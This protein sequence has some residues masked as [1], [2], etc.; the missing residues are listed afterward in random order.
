MIS[1]NPLYTT[2]TAQ[3]IPLDQIQLWCKPDEDSGIMPE[4]NMAQWLQ[5]MQKTKTN[6]Q[7]NLIQQATE[8]GGSSAT[9]GGHLSCISKEAATS[10]EEERVQKMLVEKRVREEKEQ[11]MGGSTYYIN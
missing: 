1:Y 8:E 5:P 11:E 2:W 9:S 4:M 7:P 3:L 10:S 6:K